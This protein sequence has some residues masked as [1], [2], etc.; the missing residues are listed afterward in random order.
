[1]LMQIPCKDGR[2]FQRELSPAWTCS[3]QSN[4]TDDVHASAVGLGMARSRRGS[5]VAKK[6]AVTEAYEC[7]SRSIEVG[8]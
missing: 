1:M 8:V 3:R 5:G 4:Y 7:R 6:G 2:Q